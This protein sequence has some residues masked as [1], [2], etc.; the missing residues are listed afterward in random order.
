MCEKN[1]VFVTLEEDDGRSDAVDR[2][3]RRA[4]A[5]DRFLSRIWSDQPVEVVAFELVDSLGQHFQIPNS[6]VRCT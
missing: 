3:I 6:V 2:V 5:K 1:L 4:L